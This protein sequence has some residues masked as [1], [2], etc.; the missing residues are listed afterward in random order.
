[1]LQVPAITGPLKGHG[2]LPLGGN[3]KK[4]LKRSNWRV[5]YPDSLSFRTTGGI[6]ARALRLAAELAGPTRRL[7]KSTLDI[8]RNGQT[9]MESFSLCGELIYIP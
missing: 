7:D 1:M 9:K 3:Q 4:I 8:E 2:G 6:R 5:E